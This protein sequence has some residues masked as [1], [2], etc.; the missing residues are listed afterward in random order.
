MV[1]AGG[2]ARGLRNLV[3]VLGMCV[4]DVLYMLVVYMLVVCML[5]VYMLFDH[6]VQGSHP[7]HV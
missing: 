3:H 5:V 6:E 1:C 4:V 2:Q 7:L